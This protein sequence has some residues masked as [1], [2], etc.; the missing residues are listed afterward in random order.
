MERGEASK[1]QEENV[2]NIITGECFS[3]KS[4]SR[5]KFDLGTVS[6]H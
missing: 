2:F 3:V 4:H 6:L 5:G 1:H